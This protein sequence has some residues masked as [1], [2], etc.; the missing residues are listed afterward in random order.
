MS[1][2]Y[3]GF[4]TEILTFPAT[5]DLT[6]GKVVALGQDSII[7]APLDQDFVGVL[8]TIRGSVAGVQMEGY[9][10]CRYSGTAPVPGVCGLVADASGNV[11]VS[12]DSLRK[13]RV[14]RVDTAKRVAGFIL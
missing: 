14:L 12:D 8:N 10:E 7:A 6:P 1:N 13:Y 5:G 9:V 3:F 11:K 4:H 2:S